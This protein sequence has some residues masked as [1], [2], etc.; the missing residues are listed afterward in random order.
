M[1]SSREEP[2]RQRFATFRSMDNI[3]E[4]AVSAAAWAS[5]VEGAFGWH[6][7]TDEPDF[8]HEYGRVRCKCSECAAH[9]ADMALVATQIHIERAALLLD[10]L[11]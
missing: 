6:T 2:R 3:R 7:H 5:S 11:P 10:L 4:E 1:L 9:D 8:E